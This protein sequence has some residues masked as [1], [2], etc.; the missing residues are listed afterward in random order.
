[1][2]C[3]M[4][5][6]ALRAEAE[7][8]DAER[9]SRRNIYDYEAER[10]KLC[11]PRTGEWDYEGIAFAGGTYGNIGRLDKITHRKTGE[12]KYIYWA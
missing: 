5:R 12:V 7:R 2:I 9:I 11:N 4:S 6:K 3:E 1:M 10:E 8:L